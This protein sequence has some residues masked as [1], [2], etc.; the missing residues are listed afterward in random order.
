MSEKTKWLGVVL[1]GGQSRRFGRSKALFEQPDGAMLLNR[2][3]ELLQSLAI[4]V[5][6]SARGGQELPELACPVVQ[7]FIPGCGPLGGILSVMQAHRADAYLL[8][9]CDMPLMTE[10]VLKNMLDSFLFDQSAAVYRV[11]NCVECFPLVLASSARGL[12]QERLSQGLLDIQ[13]LLQALPKVNYL[14]GDVAAEFFSNM[15][16]PEDAEKIFGIYPLQEKIL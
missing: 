1:A 5:C 10:S 8:L 2:T 3:V 13:G 11:Q 6:A 4:D 14:D 9:T 16:T 12:I 7:D 15:N